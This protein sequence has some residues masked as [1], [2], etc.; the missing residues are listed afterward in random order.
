MNRQL[1]RILPVMMCFALQASAQITVTHAD[2]EAA[3]SIE[4]TNHLYPT[5]SSAALIALAAQTGGNQTWDFTGLAYDPEYVTEVTRV[6][7]PVP[8][9]GDPH[10]AQA[11]HIFRVDS[12]DG[13]AYTFQTLR[14]SETTFLGVTDSEAWIRFVPEQLTAP[15]PFTF[16]TTWV[17]EFESEFE[18]NPLPGQTVT[19]V[20]SVDVVG[21]GTLVTPAGSTPALMIRTQTT[22]TIAFPPFSSTV[23]TLTQILFTA[24]GRLNANIVISSGG[25]AGGNY[26]VYDAAGTAEEPT[27]GPLHDVRFDA[28]APNPLRTGGTVQFTFALAASGPVRLDV[29]DVLGRPV[30]TVLDGAM[31]ASEQHKVTWTPGDLA[32]GVYVARLTAGG[33]SL[34]HRLT[35]LQ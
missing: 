35:V 13:T 31:S 28:A 27:G 3:L 4:G 9:S 26:N 15:L 18:P 6:R 25:S 8:G 17:S 20:D 14:A 19:T 2:Y 24:Y 1:L 29:L 21:W 23:T 33:Q 32:A 10:L 12:P 16:G 11:T 5:Q 34:T 22:S 30:A 7:P